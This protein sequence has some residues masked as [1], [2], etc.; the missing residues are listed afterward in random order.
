MIQTISTYTQMMMK[1]VHG[2][3]GLPALVLKYL[4]SSRTVDVSAPLDRADYVVFDSE[5]TGL[6]PKKDSIVSLGALRMKG[7][8]IS[9]GDCFYRVVEPRT[10]LTGKS[11]VIH[12]ITPSEATE[13]PSIGVLL[14][15]FLDFCGNR[16]LVGHF[17]SIDIDF[18][19]VEMKRLYGFGMQNPAVDTA[20]L[21]N[22]MRRKEE[23]VCAYH[24]GLSE[25]I[26]LFSV[27][28]RYDVPVGKAHNALDDAFVTAQLFQRFIT[29]LPQ[30]GVK[31]VKD[32]LKTARQ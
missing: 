22:W 13:C 15:E 12:G 3:K 10:K 31:T 14:P 7:G 32:L 25:D 2:Q 26:D 27:A 20:R 21:Y 18:I 29:A 9:F 1:K 24:G 16:V 23:A 4:E 17:I 8:R 5:L 28:K 19:N 30:A 11:V 6:Q